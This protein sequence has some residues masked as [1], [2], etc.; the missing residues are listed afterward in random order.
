MGFLNRFRGGPAVPEW[1]SF[2]KPAEYEAFI[3]T[4]DADLRRRG[5]AFE[6]HDGIL[7]VQAGGETPD[8]IGI[9]NLA[10]RCRMVDRSD[11]PAVIA[12]HLSSLL[13]LTGRDLDALAADFEQ[14]REILRIRLYAD[15]SMGGMTPEPE[16]PVLRPLATGILLG[17]V[18][19]F[20]DSV[21]SVSDGQLGEWPLAEDDVLTIARANTLA[22]RPPARQTV[23][24]ADGSTFE[25]MMGE[26]FY[27]A[28]RV[29]GLRALIP[30]DNVSGALVGVP[31]RHVLLWHPIVDLR[32][33]SAMTTMAS[34][35]QKMFRDGPG[36]ISNQL[37]WWKNDAL[38]HLPITPNRKG[39]DFAPPD[40]F[41]EL[42]NGLA[43]PP[44][45]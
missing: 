32:A 42:L 27:V 10:Q 22:E 30:A 41:V 13:S 39:F 23:P 6:H 7:E 14:V 11:W 19:D 8:Q 31:N 28:S 5:L 29:L 33:V 3:A 4:L 37:Y 1:A 12:E 21:A 9:L 17:L 45:G 38:I 15:E 36:S 24:G 18:Y 25:G 2:Y 16:G 43:P 44:D 20:P 35:I 26:S 40:A 34:V